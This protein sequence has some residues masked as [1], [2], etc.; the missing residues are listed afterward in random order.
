M[1]AG[2]AGRGSIAGQGKSINVAVKS[3]IAMWRKGKKA[4]SKATGQS[5]CACVSPDHW[6]RGHGKVHCHFITPNPCLQ[7]LL[8]SSHAIP[9]YTVFRSTIQSSWLQQTGT[10]QGLPIGM[11]TSIIQQGRGETSLNSQPDA[12][13][14]TRSRDQ[15]LH[16]TLQYHRIVSRLKDRVRSFSSCRFAHHRN[17]CCIDIIQS[18]IVAPHS[19]E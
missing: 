2:Q 13:K 3:R 6:G 19:K 5:R 1:K 9:H 10:R 12:I 15:C 4:T 14:F 16:Y 7:S 11:H 18:L 8:S 17:N